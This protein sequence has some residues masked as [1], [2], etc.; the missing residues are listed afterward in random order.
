MRHPV[1]PQHEIDLLSAELNALKGWSLETWTPCTV[2]ARPGQKTTI[3]VKIIYHVKTR[4]TNQ[5]QVE[6]NPI[7]SHQQIYPVMRLTMCRR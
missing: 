1:E 7:S 6:T 4:Q 5:I 2:V 3:Q